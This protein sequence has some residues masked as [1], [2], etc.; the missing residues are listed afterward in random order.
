MTKT[1]TVSAQNKS[2]LDF[3]FS[4]TDFF[5]RPLAAGNRHNQANRRAIVTTTT[6]HRQ[7]A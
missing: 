5:D 3:R 7:D 4:I 2:I 6:P 1:R